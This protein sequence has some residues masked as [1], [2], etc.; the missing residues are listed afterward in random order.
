[1]YR[2]ISCK[3]DILGLVDNFIFVRLGEGEETVSR[4]RTCERLETLR[5]RMAR[6]W[7]V[8][9]LGEKNLV[10]RHDTP[11]SLHQHRR[12]LELSSGSTKPAS[13]TIAQV[14][15]KGSR[16]LGPLPVRPEFLR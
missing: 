4:V 6:N 7:I 13:P 12:A 14:M 9:W 10:I 2:L 8:N 3:Q 15:E 11:T 5:R 16:P 1:M